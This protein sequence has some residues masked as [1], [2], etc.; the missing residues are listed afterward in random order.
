MRAGKRDS[1]PP[2]PP[3]AVSLPAPVDVRRC[4]L[5]VSLLRTICW[6]EEGFNPHFPTLLPSLKRKE[7]LE[8]PPSFSA[9]A[10]EARRGAPGPAPLSVGRTESRDETLDGLGWLAKGQGTRATYAPGEPPTPHRWFPSACVRR[11][12]RGPSV[13]SNLPGCLRNSTPSRP[14][15]R[16]APGHA[17]EMREDHWTQ[18]RSLTK[19]R[20]FGEGN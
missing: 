19:G 14:R 5:A 16:S 18:R 2:L 4:H 7:S 15:W 17:S 1:W 8:R 9:G 10:R 6:E 3:Q 13:C 20:R 12:G 11:P